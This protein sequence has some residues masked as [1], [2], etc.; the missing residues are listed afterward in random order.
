MGE[1]LCRK[2][3]DAGA[4]VAIWDIN[5]SAARELAATLQATGAVARGFAVDVSSY[6]AVQQATVDVVA[7][8]GDPLFLANCAGTPGRRGGILEVSLDEWHRVFAINL[9]GPLHTM[10]EIGAIMARRG[11][12][13]IVNISSQA[14][15]QGFP[16]VP[17]YV[18]SKTGLVGLTRAGAV[19]LA[20]HGIRV[21]AIAPGPTD[22]PMLRQVWQAHQNAPATSAARALLGRVGASEEIADLALYLLSDASS[23]VTGEVIACDGGASINGGIKA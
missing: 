1:A 20:S 9:D 2:L 12:G 11:G 23:Y 3:A 16:H 19:E 10:K 13:A 6:V 4:K 5:G 8:M 18:A 14:A 22:T 21:N 7:T 17:A 15:L